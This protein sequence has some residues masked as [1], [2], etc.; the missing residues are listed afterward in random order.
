LTYGA[1]S[2][3]N[4]YLRAGDFSASTF[5]RTEATVEAAKL[6]VDFIATMA[7]GEFGPKELDFARDYIAGVFP[8]QSETGEQVAARILAVSQYHLPA[9]YNDTYQQKV[10]GVSPAQV[11]EMAGRYFDASN[12]VLVLVGNVKEFRDAIKKEFPGATV[13]ELPFEKVDLLAPNLRR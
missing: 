2:G 11:K 5:T 8:V 3:F 7:S 9:D 4:S 6:M 12:L 1:Y 10:L 13:E